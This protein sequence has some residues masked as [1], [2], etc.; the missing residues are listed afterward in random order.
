MLIDFLI[1]Y[2]PLITAILYFV[3]AVGY[4]IRKEWAWSL[5][6]GSYSFANVGLVLAALSTKPH[7]II[8]P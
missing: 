7:N 2:I 5:V 8:V 1:K 3:V 4:G 6:W